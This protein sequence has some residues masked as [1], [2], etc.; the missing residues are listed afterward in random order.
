MMECKSIREM[1][2][3]FGDLNSKSFNNE[4]FIQIVREN[5]DSFYNTKNIIEKF[6]DIDSNVTWDFK[7]AKI[8]S[9]LY[10]YFT[11]VE[12]ENNVYVRKFAES[13]VD[14]GHAAIDTISENLKSKLFN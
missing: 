7:R 10:S 13:K 5:V 12:T 4:K 11:K 8:E 3:V 2:N 9:K 6:I 14:F 1:E